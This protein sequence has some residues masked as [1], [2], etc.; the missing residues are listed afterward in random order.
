MKFKLCKQAPSLKTVVVEWYQAHGLIPS[1][2][3]RLQAER[4]VEHIVQ[5]YLG[6]PA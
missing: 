5:K 6:T 2:R 4:V 3:Q 1:N